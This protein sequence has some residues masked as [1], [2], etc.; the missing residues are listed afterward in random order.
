MAAAEDIATWDAEAE[1]FDEPAD[2]GLRD[3]Q[4]GSVRVFGMPPTVRRARGRMGAMLQDTTGPPGLTVA[5][6]VRLTQHLY[7]RP[8]P[9][10]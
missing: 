4:A 10:S 3:P 8:A 6:T 1:A 7:P 2:H 5:E 9:V